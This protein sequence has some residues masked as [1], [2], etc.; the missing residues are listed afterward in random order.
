LCSYSSIGTFKD[1]Q[2]PLIKETYTNNYSDSLPD[3]FRHLYEKNNNEF[4]ND[5]IPV[6]TFFKKLLLRHKNT[7]RNISGLR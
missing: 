1:I 4:M 7:K 5:A 6:V 2:H 3:W